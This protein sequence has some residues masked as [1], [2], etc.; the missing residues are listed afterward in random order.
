MLKYIAG[1]IQETPV[2]GIPEITPW[3]FLVITH[4]Q[5]IPG[6]GYG[7]WK[8]ESTENYLTDGGT[9]WQKNNTIKDELYLP[10]FQETYH[11]ISD[12]NIPNVQVPTM[13]ITLYTA[14][15]VSEIQGSHPLSGKKDFGDQYVH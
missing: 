5:H 8:K 10:L 7:T 2:E 15:K 4:L 6:T 1:D 12:T 14:Q 9:P 11:R 13:N 3:T